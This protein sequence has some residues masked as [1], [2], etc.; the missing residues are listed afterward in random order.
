MI[1]YDIP[2]IPHYTIYIYMCMYIICDYI[3]IYDTYIYIYY[4]IYKI[5]YTIYMLYHI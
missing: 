4:Y 2:H 3:Y 5:I 1:Y